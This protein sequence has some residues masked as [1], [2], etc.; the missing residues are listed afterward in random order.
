M[1]RSIGHTVRARLK[2]LC[3][4]GMTSVQASTQEL[5]K[6]TITI[7]LQIITAATTTTTTA[8][9]N[10]NICGS[11]FRFVFFFIFSVPKI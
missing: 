6:I 8:T 4:L 10:N 3:L 1:A 11:S 7:V 2:T 5:Y 9:Q